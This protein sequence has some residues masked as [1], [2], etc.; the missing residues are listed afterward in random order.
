MNYTNLSL[1]QAPSIAA[2]LRFF[3]TAPIFLIASSLLLIFYGDEILLHRWLPQTLA[4][5][6]LITLGFIS[7][8]IIGAMFQL[9]P[10]L[11]GC[12]IPHA[13]RI[14][15][16]IYILYC[17]GIVFLAMGFIYS[18]HLYQILAL[19]LLGSALVIFLGVISLS[20]FKSKSIQA[21]AQGI[22]ISIISFWI[23]IFLALALLSSYFLP[24]LPLLRQYTELH[25]GW[26][27]TGWIVIMVTSVAYQVI[28]MFQITHEYPPLVQRYFS[29][30][31]FVSL[32]LWSLF[33]TYEIQTGH[34]LQWPIYFIIIL[35]I[36][37]IFIFVFLSIKLLSQRKKRMADTSLYFWMSSLL[38]LLASLL[39]F[40]FS[41]ITQTDLA[42]SIGIL[43]FAG[44]AMSVN[45]GMLYKIIPFLIWLNL[46]K[47]LSSSGKRLSGIPSIYE[48]ISHK[49]S[50]HLF[51]LYIMALITTLIALN[52]PSLF[53]YPASLLWLLNGILLTYHLFKAFRIY[54]TFA[55]T[56]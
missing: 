19:C 54:L 36:T 28:P 15:F 13:N 23:T 4:L 24:S 52:Y 35:C 17:P 25:I 42:M 38:N 41:Q 12:H 22:K 10:V 43:F 37:L 51:I 2:P 40:V 20:L 6:H 21:S 55:D 18:S 45:I 56:H 34:S 33:R 8:S 29:S 1:E 5:T 3:L 39:L 48:I 49:Q 9:L 47:R 31:I 44:F 27:M 53:F 50:R 16:I 30:L 46:H 26:G 11:A 14:S 7:M 32:I